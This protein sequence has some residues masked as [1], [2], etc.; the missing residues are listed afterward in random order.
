M[1]KRKLIGSLNADSESYSQQSV[2]SISEAL[3]EVFS[4]NTKEIYKEYLGDIIEASCEGKIE[5]ISDLDTEIKRARA[6]RA[7]QNVVKHSVRRFSYGPSDY[8]EPQV[9]PWTIEF[10]PSFSKNLKY[11]DTKNKGRILSAVSELTTN[12]IVVR[13]DTIKPLSGDK[14]GIWRYRIGDYRLVY[15]PKDPPRCVKLLDFSSRGSVY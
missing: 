9:R 12:A 15:I 3:D 13:G 5:S 2:E 6:K 4:D 11:I 1:K 7:P 14:E 8:E 10:T